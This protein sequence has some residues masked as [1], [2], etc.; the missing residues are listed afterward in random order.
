MMVKSYREAHVNSIVQ[1][2]I[3]SKIDYSQLTPM[4]TKLVGNVFHKFYDSE[5]NVEGFVLNITS[6]T[7]YFDNLNQL[8]PV[9]KVMPDNIFYYIGEKCPENSV[10][11]SRNFLEVYSSNYCKDY[12]IGTLFLGV[13]TSVAALIGG[14][15][16]GVNNKDTLAGLALA[17]ALMGALSGAFFSAVCNNQYPDSNEVVWQEFKTCLREEIIIGDSPIPE[18][19]S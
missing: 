18:Y 1:Q 11:I 14:L 10:E 19:S 13:T 16:G 12:T 3:I 6:K 2:D 17:P 4:Q 7:E 15:L 9:S 8:L 5:A